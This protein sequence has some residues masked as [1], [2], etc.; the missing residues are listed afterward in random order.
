ME[1]AGNGAERTLIT[2]NT[3]L[4]PG[5]CTRAEQHLWLLNDVDE[6]I[7]RPGSA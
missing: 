2:L 4:S 6:N 5:R 1:Q 7:R 3:H